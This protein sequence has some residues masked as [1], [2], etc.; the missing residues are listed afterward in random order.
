[1]PSG[2]APYSRHC[3]P[4][5]SRSPLCFSDKYTWLWD[6]ENPNHVDVQPLLYAIDYSPKPAIAQM[7]AVLQG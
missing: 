1:M 3:L 4:S 6:F 2:V 5:P 7:L